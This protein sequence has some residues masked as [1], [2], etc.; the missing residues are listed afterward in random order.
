VSIATWSHAEDTGDATTFADILGSLWPAWPDD[1]PT[2]RLWVLAGLGAFAQLVVLLVYALNKFHHFDLSE[3]YGIVNQATF[4]IAHGHLNP[5]DTIYQDQFWRDQFSLMAWPLALVRLVTRSGL[6]LLVVQS[7][8]LA[9]TTLTVLLAGIQVVSAQRLSRSLQ[10][11]LLASLAFITMANPWLYEAASFDFHFQSIATVT[12][13][14]A[15]LGFCG[16]HHRVAWVMIGLTLLCGSSEIL[17]VIGVGLGFVLIG[18]YRRTGLA[19]AVVGVLWLVVDLAFGA[20]Q[21]TTFALSY[22]YL[23]TTHQPNPAALAIAQGVVLH[24]GHALGVLTSRRLAIGEILGYGGILG[25]LFPP[26]GVATLVAILANGL[27]HSGAFLSLQS[28]GFQNLPEV[29]LLLVGTA[30]VW[31]WLLCGPRGRFAKRVT[32]KRWPLATA[33]A[34]VSLIIAVAGLGIDAKIPPLWLRVP[35][36]AASEFA[37]I[38]IPASDEVIASEGVVGRFSARLE[39]FGIFD[40]EQHFQACSST[41]FVVVAADNGFQVSPTVKGAPIIADLDH[42]R[43]AHRRVDGPQVQI[44]ELVDQQVGTFLSFSTHHGLLVSRAPSFGDERCSDEDGRI[45]S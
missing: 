41:I 36:V 6:T 45:L 23:A 3:D 10:Y 9:A 5:F 31:T 22:G 2:R 27:Q 28:G 39:V 4:E 7:L 8:A 14:L 17:L 13:L 18:K 12:L 1:T 19:V 21:S 44:F 15:V 11:T 37:S 34:L 38:A 20:H 35:P 32:S 40:A 25:V 43:D 24:P 42:D 29:A 30:C 33:I 16:R 26:A